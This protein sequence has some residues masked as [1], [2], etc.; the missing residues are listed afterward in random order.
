MAA[1]ATVEWGEDRRVRLIDRIFGD[2]TTSPMYRLSL[3][4]VAAGV[5]SVALFAVAEVLPWITIRSSSVPGAFAPGSPSTRDT[6]IEGAAD[7]AVFAYYIGMVLLLMVVSAAMVS[8]PHAR[9]ALV[10]AGVGLVAALL[11]VILGLIGKAAEGGDLALFYEVEATAGSGPYVAIAAVLAA[12][13][14]LALSGWH[15]HRAIGRRSDADDD[16][17][18]DSDD[19]EP[20]PI[21]LTV[22][23]G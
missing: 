14:A 4:G 18:G 8:R 22:S 12:A 15:P 13:A 10:A 2:P 23:S 1:D 17:D 7:G 5:I 3:P 21:D 11:V 19:G 9:R 20:G 6:S 16:E